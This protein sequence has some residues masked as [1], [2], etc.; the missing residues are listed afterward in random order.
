MNGFPAV[1]QDSPA[2]PIIHVPTLIIEANSPS[3]S[4][5]QSHPP[6]VPTRQPRILCP[7]NSSEPII[8]DEDCRSIDSKVTNESELSQIS[9]NREIPKKNTLR[10]S[11]V[12]LFSNN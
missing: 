12:K 7:V 11:F 9:N 3:S 6:P 5:T 10:R 8:A 2:Q 1:S 4:A